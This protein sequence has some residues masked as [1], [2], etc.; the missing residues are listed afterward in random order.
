MRKLMDPLILGDPAQGGFRGINLA[1]SNN[2]LAYGQSPNMYNWMVSSTGLE[3]RDGE[4]KDN[5]TEISSATGVTG[6]FRFFDSS[7][8]KTFVKVGTT[9][10][11]LAPTG[12]SASACAATLVAATE[13]EFCSW[14]SSCF[15]ADEVNLYRATTGLF[16]AVSF[17][18]E[19][20]NAVLTSD[21]PEPMCPVQ[22]KEHLWFID[23]SHRTRVVF[24]VRDYYDRLFEDPLNAGQYGSWLACDRDDGIDLVGLIRDGTELLAFKPHKF[25]RIS[26]D[27][28]ATTDTTDVSPGAS[29]GA[30]SQKS[31]VSCP[32]GV[33]F[34][35][36]DGIWLY[37]RDTGLTCLSLNK[38]L[39]LDIKS[40]LDGVT[41]ANKAKICCGYYNHL[42]LVWYPYGSSTY[43]NRGMALDL[44]KMEWQPFRDWNISRF[45]I[46]ED[47]TVHA[48]RAN[49][50]FV[51]KLFTGTDDN[52][53][54]ITSYYETKWYGTPGVEMVLDAV[55]GRILSGR[56]LTFGWKSDAAT[57]ISGSY[58]FTYGAAPIV[59]GDR[60]NPG[61]AGK[62]TWG[63]RDNPGS[64]SSW[65]DRTNLVS[66]DFAKRMA[67]QVRYK[68][69]QFSFYKSSKEKQQIDFFNCY[70]FPQ[71]RAKI[72]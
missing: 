5:G 35:G 47:D 16:T 56:S 49:A 71:R 15:F 6:L 8:D 13:I 25:F 59:W 9:V 45:C 57:N 26:G 68:E 44:N 55:E 54:A 69:I 61:G 64:G 17:L 10:Y 42:F 53:A 32:M 27:Y 38:Q 23:A 46:F 4:L 37:R 70:S 1:G 18:D 2:D 3:T 60:D 50:G 43:C 33:I 41:D 31:I 7:T 51:D 58:P 39:G 20:G 40:E 24:T 36:P 48:G 22:H 66:I 52:G 14:F 30:Y 28:D 21:V 62:F 12:A 11:T 29:V 72:G 63:N 67:G 19:D 65:S 34:C